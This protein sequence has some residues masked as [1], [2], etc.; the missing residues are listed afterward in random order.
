MLN[1]NNLCSVALQRENHGQ[2]FLSTATDNTYRQSKLWPSTDPNGPEYSSI[3]EEKKKKKKGL[4][5]IWGLVTGSVKNHRNGH[6]NTSSFSRQEDNLP[7]TPPPPLSYLVS[8]GP[9]EVHANNNRHASSPSLPAALKQ[10]GN[11][12]TSPDMY[13][14]H[15]LTSSLI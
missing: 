4:A 6:D 5:K 13:D 15:S 1:S 2:A 10:G 11:P 8:R 3:T 14:K 12:G 7:L 9:S